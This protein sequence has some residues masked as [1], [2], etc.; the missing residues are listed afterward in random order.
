MSP[1]Q[2]ST[3]RIATS[4]NSR[5]ESTVHALLSI[6]GERLLEG[7]HLSEPPQ[8]E[9]QV[10]WQSELNADVWDH[11]F[12]GVDVAGRTWVIWGQTTNYK[13]H[14]SGKPESNKTYEVRET[15]TEALTM[16]ATW[17]RSENLRT[18][19]VTIGPADYA[20]GWFAPMKSCSF[21]RSLYVSIAGADIFEGID[22]L[23]ASARTESQVLDKVREAIASESPIG[24]ALR[25]PIDDLLHWWVRDGLSPNPLA[26]AQAELIRKAK[27]KVTEVRSVIEDGTADNFKSA[28]VDSILARQQENDDPAIQEVVAQTLEAKPFLASAT[29]QLYD[30]R[31]FCERVDT[32]A[33]LRAPLPIAIAELWQAQAPDMRESLRR[34]LIRMRSED[35]LDYIQD[36]NVAGLSEHNLYG[37]I[38]S[39][40]QTTKVADIIANRLPHEMTTTSQL[41]EAIKRRGRQT[42]REQIYFEAR[43]GTNAAM[44]FRAVIHLLTNDGF[45]VKAAST[46]ERPLIGYQRDLSGRTVRPYTN[47]QVVADRSGNDLAIIKAKHFS[48]REF[49]RRCKEEGFVGLSLSKRWVDGS[50]KSGLSLPL[51]MLIDVEDKSDLAP[52]GVAKLMAMGWT[53]V[54][55]YP[56]LKKLV[57]TLAR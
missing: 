57:T 46:L 35:D 36:V 21:D 43:N 10:R 53:V 15:L 20:Y 14:A 37:P 24:Q 3:Q 54:V 38:H 30:W 9:S 52:H 17:P 6:L 48:A 47:F 40:E 26:D 56:A 49:D 33:D 18:I 32:L 39:R 44:S 29:R 8:V 2:M 50:F 7:G 42:L 55:G 1:S 51:V 5:A 22:A 27:P 13:G 11:R 12:T 45:L 34:I 31:F 19:H 28:V 16:R 4:R 41:I 23:F 25:E